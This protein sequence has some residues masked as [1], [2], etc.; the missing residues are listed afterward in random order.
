MRK[1][2]LNL[3]KERT[4]AKETKI[5]LEKNWKLIEWRADSHQFA[6]ESKAQLYITELWNVNKSVN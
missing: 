2:Q 3:H 4:K 6:L 5:P 1:T